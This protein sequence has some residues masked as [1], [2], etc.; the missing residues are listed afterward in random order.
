[1]IT[2]KIMQAEVT[3]KYIVVEKIPEKPNVSTLRLRLVSGGVPAFIAGQ[4]ITVYFPETGTP[5]GKAYSISSPPSQDSIAIT[6]KAIGEFSNRLVGLRQGDTVTGS[7]P[8]GYFYSESSDNP[9]VLLAAGVGIAPFRSMVHDRLIETPLRY[10]SLFSSVKKTADILF[11]KEF[12]ILGERHRN[13]KPHYYI[14]Q[15]QNISNDMTAGRI[16]AR[17]VLDKIAL[18]PSTEFLLCGSISFTRD[19]W[20]DLRASGIPEESIYTE[21]FF[22]NYLQQ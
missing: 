5:E 6:V 15:E 7:L 1:M 13:F 17:R 14:T 21:A 8:Y 22:S 10:I 11:K 16:T 19:L 3:T 4:F 2:K 18:D 20:R 12:D 9:L